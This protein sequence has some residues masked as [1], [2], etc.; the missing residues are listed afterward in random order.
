MR[1]I[2]TRAAVGRCVAA[3]LPAAAALAL[4]LGAHA[5]SD[6]GVNWDPGSPA[7]KEYAIP[8]AQ[9]RADGAGTDNQ[10]A[11][12]NTAFGVGLK[13]PAGGAGAGKGSR[14]GK[15][16]SRAG[17]GRGKKSSAAQPAISPALAGQI[18]KAEAPGGTTVLTLGMALAVLLA[19][20]A[21][22]VALRGRLPQRVHRARA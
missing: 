11:A 20:A 6:P 22:A 12:A 13:P 1:A 3:A 5:A 17:S 10:Q 16:G 4:P 7:A 15:K 8:L 19:A 18:A 21:L 14:A 9:G 2:R